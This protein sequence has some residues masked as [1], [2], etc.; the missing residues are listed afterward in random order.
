[1]KKINFTFLLFLIFL[2]LRIPN[3]FTLLTNEEANYFVTLT[4]DSNIYGFPHPPMAFWS[5]KILGQLFGDYLFV[6]RLA[7]FIYS[8]LTFWLVYY[9]SKRFFNQ[10]TALISVLILTVSFGQMQSSHMLDT[11]SIILAFYS[12]LTIFA[13]YFFLEKNS[14]TS[15]IF[16]GISLGTALLTKISAI[17][18]FGVIGL[19]L[20]LNVNEKYKKRVSP[21]IKDCF[22]IALFSSITFSVFP[23]HDFLVYNGMNVYSTILRMLSSAATSYGDSTHIFIL[24]RVYR[25]G[26]F[27]VYSSPPL[28]MFS[29]LW[30]LRFLKIFYKFRTGC[31]RFS[32]EKQVLNPISVHVLMQVVFFGIFFS[33][34]QD[35]SRYLLAIIPMLC[36]LAGNYLSEYIFNKKKLIITTLIALVFFN[37]FIL[38]GF[39]IKKM[40]SFNEPQK[41][42]GSIQN[43]DYDFYIPTWGAAG[44]K[45]LFLDFKV[46]MFSVIATILLFLIILIIKDSLSYFVWIALALLISYNLFFGLEN[47]F[48]LTSPNIDKIKER[49]IDYAIKNDLKEPIA[50]SHPELGVYLYEKY[51]ETFPYVKD[52][53]LKTKNREHLKNAFLIK[54][55]AEFFDELIRIFKHI[56][57]IRF[58]TNWKTKENIEF[59]RN[60]II[61]THSTIIYIDI[62]YGDKNGDLWKLIIQNCK[63]IKEFQDKKYKMAYI[64]E[65]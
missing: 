32:F 38:S 41:F 23:I 42:I 61:N 14:L 21:I 65:C 25:L 16:L 39:E 51:N 27:V 4:Q 20:L 36:I 64:F 54:K 19:T 13:L 46:I 48:Y 59:V 60:N 33:P 10:R 17:L 9:L 53:L 45:F 56:H 6:Y 43:F 49:V 52:S 63:V 55:N 24:N 31:D 50:L 5:F 26:Q 7:P 15:K 18:L 2:A 30:F 40:F 62:P 8:A 11:D 37:M 57:L 22:I 44:P 12:L 34:L 3:I 1:M 28:L 47:T 58:D 35:I 29:L